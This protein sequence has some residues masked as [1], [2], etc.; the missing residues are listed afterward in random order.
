[1]LGLK[2]IRATLPLNGVGSKSPLS[3]TRGYFSR[4]SLPAR[5]LFAAGALLG[6]ICLFFAEENWRGRRAWEICRRRLEAKGVEL[7]WQKF[8]PPPVAADENF[9]E[10]PFLAPLFDFNPRAPGQSIWRD[11]AGH[12]RAANFGAILLPSDNLGRIPSPRWEGKMT[13]LEGTCALLQGEAGRSAGLTRSFATRAEAATAVLGHLEDYQPVLDELRAASRRPHSRFNIAYNAE[14]PI[15]ILLPHYLVLQRACRVLELK[16][17]AELALQKT[18]A[19]FEDVQLMLYLAGSIRDEPFLMGVM[20]LSSMLD[21]SEQI[22]WE[23]L[24]G[25]HWTEPQLEELE[26]KLKGNAVLTELERGLQA[27]RAAFGETAFRYIRAH[28]NVLR[29]WIAST[30][31]AGR[32]M[33]LLAGPSGWFY[34]EQVSYHRLYDAR[35][36]A[37]L[38]ASAARVH[39]HVIDENRKA[40]EHEL[41]LSSLWRHT[42]FARLMLGQTS[43][44]IQRGALEQ[45]RVDQTLIACALERYRLSNG[46]FPE[47]LETLIPRFTGQLPLDVCTGR[48][49]KY[50]LL[51]DGRFVL[52]GLGWNESDEGG[53]V[54]LKPDGGDTNPDEGDWVW[55]QYPES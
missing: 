46:K 51:R 20:S 13:D 11:I 49:L 41:Q 2:T 42:G 28:K 22:V 1:M 44:T 16:A 5:W 23:G 12:D 17:S 4:L 24:A 9:A 52:Y 15:S 43:E 32:L 31:D 6:L 35:V 40:L 19:A 26:R 37:G 8:A 45:N 30:D 54:V 33:Y 3:D 48:P 47:T 14:D 55:P 10:T 38:E 25:R 7:D 36:L 21:R 53:V 29:S 50:R 27:E 34:Q 39:P 18:E